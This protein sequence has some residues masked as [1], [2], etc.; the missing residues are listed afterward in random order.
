MNQ[1]EYWIMLVERVYKNHEQING[2]ERK[3]WLIKQLCGEI[4]SSGIISY[5]ENYGD[6]YVEVRDILLSGNFISLVDRIDSFSV[7]LFGKKPPGSRL[8]YPGLYAKVDKDLESYFGKYKKLEKWEANSYE[9]LFEETEIVHS[10]ITKFGIDV[11]LFEEA[12]T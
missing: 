10:W 1:S 8:K 9:I 5:F 4:W 12:G 3:Y 2:D 6:D 7:M 11:S